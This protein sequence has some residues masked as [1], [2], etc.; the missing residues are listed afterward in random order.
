LIFNIQPYKFWYY[1]CYTTKVTNT[2]NSS[3]STMLHILE[4]IPPKESVPPIVEF[5]LINILFNFGIERHPFCNSGIQQ[6]KQLAIFSYC[7]QIRSIPKL[8]KQPLYGIPQNSFLFR[9]IPDTGWHL[10]LLAYH[11]RSS[12]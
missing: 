9:P 7:I 8:L 6:A 10:H 4:S 12:T 2:E 5:H 3:Y 1:N 11:F